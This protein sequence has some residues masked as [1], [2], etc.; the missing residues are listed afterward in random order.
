MPPSG[1]SAGRT[2]SGSW[3][4]MCL[5]PSS[6]SFMTRPCRRQ[7]DG[8]LAVRLPGEPGDAVAVRCSSRPTGCRVDQR[9]PVPVDPQRRRIRGSFGFV[10]VGQ[11]DS[12]GQPVAA[13][14]PD[15]CQWTPGA[16]P[17]MA[18]ALVGAIPAALRARRGRRR[19]AAI[20]DTDAAGDLE[21]W[22]SCLL[23]GTTWSDPLV[24]WAVPGASIR[25][26]RPWSATTW[27][28]GRGSPRLDSGETASRPR[29]LALTDGPPAAAIFS[30]NDDAMPRSVARARRTEVTLV[31]VGRGVGGAGQEPRDQGQPSARVSP[32][33]VTGGPPITR[34]RSGRQSAILTHTHESSIIMAMTKRLQVLVD[35]A[36]LREIQRAARRSR[37]TV[38]EWVRMG[39]REIR[40]G[41]AARDVQT[42]L[43][44]IRRAASHAYPTG[45]IQ[46]LLDETARGRLDHHQS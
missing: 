28:V 30:G 21:D 8:F 44:A 34:A 43:D 1:S 24:P 17:D 6:D 23:D 20:A 3:C 16:S 41:Q 19:H 42:K 32:D 14:S 45:D 4:R 37:M 5:R 15:G 2:S 11:T 27:S 22:S 7:R 39:L 26:R 35:D 12:L 18:G 31:G 40:A 33:R 13:L 29:G 9:E 25:G 10:G 36:E 38:S 46:Q